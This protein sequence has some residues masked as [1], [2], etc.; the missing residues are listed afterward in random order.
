MTIDLLRDIRSFRVAVIHP[1]DA[2][3]D[4][5]LRQLRRIGCEVTTHWPPP[6]ERPAGVDLIFLDMTKLLSEQGKLSWSADADGPPIVA[7]LD[8]ESPTVLQALVEHGVCGFVGK[9]VRPFG[10]LTTM[11]LAHHTAAEARKAQRRLA[12][13]ERRLD[14]LKKVAKA[15]AILIDSRRISEEEAYRLLRERAMARRT[16]IEAVAAAI[17]DATEIL[18][19]ENRCV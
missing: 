4:E 17:I 1:R 11:F 3:M 8:Y 12:K 6:K 7:L 19:S 5:L 2:E 10:L 13:A 16:T 9:P 15:K 14:G 18:S